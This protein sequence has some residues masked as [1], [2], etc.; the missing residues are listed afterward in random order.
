MWCDIL[1]LVHDSTERLEFVSHFFVSVYEW[2]DVAG[3]VTVLIILMPYRVRPRP[4]PPHIGRDDMD[5]AQVTDGTDVDQLFFGRNVPHLNDVHGFPL[6]FEATIRESEPWGMVLGLI[7][8]PYRDVHSLDIATYRTLA[9]AHVS[10]VVP[11]YLSPLVHFDGIG[12]CLGLSSGRLSI[13]FFLILF[14]ANSGG[15]VN[16]KVTSSSIFLSTA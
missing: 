9:K 3:Y 13:P 5:R 4:G 10:D 7:M 8:G 1:Q 6:A 14:I 16:K 2:A 15:W 12:H 11:G